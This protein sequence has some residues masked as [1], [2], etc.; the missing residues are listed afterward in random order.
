MR[1][2]APII[3]WFCR[4]QQ[5][6]ELSVHLLLPLLASLLFVCGLICIKRTNTAGVNPWTVTFLANQWAAL[7]FSTLWLLGGTGQPWTMLWQPA[8]IAVLFICGQVF[9]FSAIRYGDVSL[10]T[11]I[12]GIKV[13]LV[14]FL[15]TFLFQHQLN[16]SV[17]FAAAMATL[18]I[19]LVQWSPR[20]KGEDQERSEDRSG[21]L[22]TVLL[23]ILAAAA[24]ALFDVVVQAWSPAWGPGRILPIVF[25]MVSLLSFGFL[26]FFQTELFRKPEIKKLLLPGTML[27]GTQALCIVF[28]LSNFG[29][30][31]RVNVVYSLRALW[32]VGLAWLAAKIWGGSEA[33]LPANVLA[34]R[35]LGAGLLTVAVVL[36]ILSAQVVRS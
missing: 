9:T 32:G 1:I 8:L 35:F 10:A 5:F 23:S 27:I 33:K 30:A 3:S 24:F 13:V 29:D 21:I 22:L 28:T 26:P 12:V 11:P 4:V 31:A 19:G 7:L 20:Q 16:S 2:K 18:G 15:L 36:V 6:R 25:W 14:A 17:W 34:A